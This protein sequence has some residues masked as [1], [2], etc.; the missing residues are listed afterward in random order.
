[1]A[2]ASP[3]LNVRVQVLEGDVT[4]L[5]NVLDAHDK[6][7]NG[8]GQPGAKT[9]LKTV[10]DA[11]VRIEAQLKSLTTAAW[12]LASTVIGGGVLWFL[13]QFLPKVVTK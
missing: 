4:D 6:F 11:T 12:A 2:T 3:T 13:T 7:I 10:E 1:M 5:R 8:N 9:R